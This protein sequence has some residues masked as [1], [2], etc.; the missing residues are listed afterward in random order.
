MYFFL[1]GGAFFSR[2]LILHDIPLGPLPGFSERLRI[3]F[4]RLKPGLA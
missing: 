1:G 3:A 2:V 4:N